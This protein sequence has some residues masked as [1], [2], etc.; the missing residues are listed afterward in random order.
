MKSLTEF[1]T[2]LSAPFRVG[3]TTTG[4]D[5]LSELP[6]TSIIADELFRS[7]R[8]PATADDIDLAFQTVTGASPTT[9]SL[10]DAE[11]FLHSLG[12]LAL[13]K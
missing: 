7:D 4:L 13:E 5:L 12:F 9:A 8:I 11:V 10:I 1:L 2:T 3:P 6:L